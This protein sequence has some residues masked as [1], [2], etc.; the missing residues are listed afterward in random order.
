MYSPFACVQ[1]Y[2][3]LKLMWFRWKHLR[4]EIVCV[5]GLYEILLKSED[6]SKDGVLRGEFW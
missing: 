1:F 3:S 6:K 4:M 5:Y 2:N